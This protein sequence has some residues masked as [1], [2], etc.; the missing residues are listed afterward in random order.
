MYRYALKWNSNCTT[1]YTLPNENG[2]Q[3]VV[4]IWIIEKEMNA[5]TLQDTSHTDRDSPYLYTDRE[6]T[7]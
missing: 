3:Y 2:C 1:D 7:K 6:C 5:C 4:R